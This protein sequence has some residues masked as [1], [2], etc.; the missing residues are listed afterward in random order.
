MRL[1]GGSGNSY[2]VTGS[3]VKLN[4]YTA[5][6]VLAGAPVAAGDLGTVGPQN[7]KSYDFGI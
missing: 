2:N 4:S 5:S 7:V 1:R 3:Q 6:S